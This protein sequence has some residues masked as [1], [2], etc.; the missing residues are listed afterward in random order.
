MKLSADASIDEL[1][2]YCAALEKEVA[3]LTSQKDQL[4]GRLSWLEEQF[5]LAQKGCADVFLDFMKPHLDSH[6]TPSDSS[7][8]E[9]S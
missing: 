2:A 6:D 9:T 3:T 5:R 1:R 8:L 7:R 4:E